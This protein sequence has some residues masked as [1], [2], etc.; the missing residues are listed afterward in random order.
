MNETE[1]KEFLRKVE[2]LKP[3]QFERLFEVLHHHFRNDGNH[4]NLD[5][6]WRLKQAHMLIKHQNHPAKPA[7]TS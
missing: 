1:L 3:N 4:Y 2:T 6:A 5:I 7:T